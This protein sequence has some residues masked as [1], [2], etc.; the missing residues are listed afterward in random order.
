M[1]LLLETIVMYKKVIEMLRAIRK[2]KKERIKQFR[3][4]NNQL[5]PISFYLYVGFKIH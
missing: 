5:A 1:L 3:V 4:I 2:A